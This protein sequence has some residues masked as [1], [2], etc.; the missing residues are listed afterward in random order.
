MSNLLAI[1][2]VRKLFLELN[3]PEGQETFSLLGRPLEVWVGHS[4]EAF[5]GCTP[6][7]VLAMP[8]GDVTV[9]SWLERRLR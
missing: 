7:Q 3:V 1:A 6:A 9:R 5:H 4:S 8:N 2:L